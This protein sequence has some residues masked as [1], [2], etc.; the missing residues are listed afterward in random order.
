MC[1]GKAIRRLRACG[2]GAGPKPVFTGEVKFGRNKLHEI[3]HMVLLD[4]R[5]DCALT[6][7]NVTTP[8]GQI[9]S[10]HNALAAAEHL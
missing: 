8:G 2:E 6:V 7:S 10:C 5:E 3:M 9:D 4:S 1:H